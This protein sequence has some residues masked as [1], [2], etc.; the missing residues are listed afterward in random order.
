MQDENSTRCHKLVFILCCGLVIIA[1]YKAFTA[2]AS[3]ADFENL[4]RGF[5]ADLPAATKF[6]LQYPYTG[7]FIPIIAT[8]CCAYVAVRWSS[9]NLKPLLI[10]IVACIVIAEIFNQLFIK[11]MYAPIMQMGKVVGGV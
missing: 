5:G 2:F 1:L 7:L 10:A 8:I 3:V 6:I 11:A 9:I 4:Y